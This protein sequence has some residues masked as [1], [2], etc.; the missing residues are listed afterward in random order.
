[1]WAA[2]TYYNASP[3]RYQTLVVHFNGTTVDDGG[4]GRLPYGQ[5]RD[6]RPCG[7]PDGV[8]HSPWSAG[9]GPNALIEQANCPSGPV[10]LPTRAPAPVPPLPAAPGV[11]PAP[12]PPPNTPPPTTPIPVTITDQAAAA[13]IG[14]PPDWS[15]SAAVAD[16]NG[17]G[18][19]DLFI[20]HHWHPANLWINNQDGTFSAADV[21]YLQFHPGPARLPGR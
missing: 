19:P 9:Q 18:W 3:Q 1:M 5:R 15:F 8:E 20:S 7:Q 14:G 12:S 6:H 11:G 13:G 21:S 4:L 10:S 16:L 17:D 2:G